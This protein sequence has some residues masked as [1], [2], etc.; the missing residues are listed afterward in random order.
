MTNCGDNRSIDARTTIAAA[1]RLKIIGVPS[2]KRTK[3]TPN[4][5]I[6]ELMF[7]HL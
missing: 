6:K 5:T 7:H 3:K 1:A 4:K 2:N